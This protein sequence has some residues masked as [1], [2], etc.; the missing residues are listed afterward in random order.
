MK[1]IDSHAHL[2]DNAFDKDRAALVAGA[3]AQGLGIVN[4]G[5]SLRSSQEAVELSSRYRGIW[6]TVGAHPH[7]AKHVDASTLATF[8]ALAAEEQVVAIGEIGLDYYRDLS[9]RDVQQQVFEQQLRLAQRL[10]LPVVLH[11]RESTEDLI[12]VLEGVSPRHHGVVHS[13]LGDRALAERFLELG[14]D[15]GIGGPLTYP[16]NRALREAVRAVP[17][18]R[19]LLE[20]DCPYLTP[21]PYRGRRNE[22]AYIQYVAEAI[23]AL[24]DISIEDVAAQTLANT[25]RVFRLP[26]TA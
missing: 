6:A 7:G 10:N 26:D 1:W 17:L 4:V 2:N 11:N 22:P 9:P 8:E 19:M 5:S 3:F 25:Q 18:D 16:K 23:A 24:K 20:T 12:A 13:F 14:L 21:V 15:L